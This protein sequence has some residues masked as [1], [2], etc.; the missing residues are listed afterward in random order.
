M[1]KIIITI[2]VLFAYL[3]SF[4][5]DI[6][7]KMKGIFSELDRKKI[8][9]NIL[10]NRTIEHV[11]MNKYVGSI[12]DS[13]VDFRAWISLYN[14]IQQAYFETGLPTSKEI[15]DKIGFDMKSMKTIN[16]VIPIGILDFTYNR[17]KPD[18]YDRGLLY[19]DNDKV[20][21]ST[22]NEVEIYN[23]ERCFAACALTTPI[24]NNGNTVDFEVDERY[25]FSNTNKTIKTI[26]ID[27]D[28]GQGFQKININ[29][30]KSIYYESGTTK[31]IRVN[32][33][34]V[35]GESLHS[36]IKLEFYNEYQ[37]KSGGGGGIDF[38]TVSSPNS[39]AAISAFWPSA[40]LNVTGTYG[41]WDACADGI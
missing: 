23:I 7:Q 37:L 26:V 20:Y 39:S 31:Q 15:L 16:D 29:T 10:I 1:R 33:N 40:G 3:V 22:I 21:P 8:E 13:I 35:D 12:N 9:T 17:V 14:Q 27:F 32:V 28:D 30:I 6:S 41:V 34:Y 25:I 24:E 18:A 36:T 11:P 4:S 5:Q 19:M 38:G 2:T